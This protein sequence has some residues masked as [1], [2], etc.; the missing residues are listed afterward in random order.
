MHHAAANFATVRLR[1]TD[2]GLTSP[3]PTMASVSTGRIPTKSMRLGLLS[4]RERVRLVNGN[5]DLESTPGEGTTIMVWVP[6]P[7]EGTSL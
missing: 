3:S 1:R 6:V 2:G 7:T 4:M 5:L